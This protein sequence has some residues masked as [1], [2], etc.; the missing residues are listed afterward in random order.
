MS[1]LVAIISTITCVIGCGTLVFA[2][3]ALEASKHP[4]LVQMEG[5]RRRAKISASIAFVMIGLPAFGRDTFG[6]CMFVGLVFG[7][8]GDVALLGRTARA[9]M[10]GLGAFLVGHVA[11][12][13]GIAQIVPPSR[14]LPE[15]HVLA[16]LPV[17]VAIGAMIQLWPKLDALK[18]P[19]IAYVVA[20]VVM[21]IAAYATHDRMIAVG[22]T[23]FFASDLA[24]A[25]ERFLARDFR[26]KLYGLPAY[27]AAQLLIAWAIR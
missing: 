26:N 21:V 14:W 4:V 20:I 13:V 19:V 17:V 1:L 12:A 25:R 24:V 6:T 11:Y 8:L 16:V 27:Y 2:E 7:A 18:L 23:L 3:H 5:V 9:F 22:A 10:L 15:A